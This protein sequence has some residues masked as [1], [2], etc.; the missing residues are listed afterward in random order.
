MP[1]FRT[2][3]RDEWLKR[4]EANAVQ[5][6]PL[7]NIA[8]AMAEPQVRHLGLTEELEHAKAGKLTFIRGPVKYDNLNKKKSKPPQL[9][10]E[11]TIDILSEIEY[12]QGA[13]VEFANKGISR[14]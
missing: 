4:L 12:G 7:C 10:R 2:R 5:V 3:T 8:E 1:T 11:Q 14:I 9:L 13:I 6:A